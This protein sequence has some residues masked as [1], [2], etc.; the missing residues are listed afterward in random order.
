MSLDGRILRRHEVNVL[1]R[2]GWPKADVMRQLNVKHKFVDLWWNRDDILDRPREGRPIKYTRQLVDRIVHRLIKKGTRSSTRLV[3]QD[4]GYPRT[5]VRRVAHAAGLVSKARHHHP[6]LS[7]KM[8]QERVAFSRAHKNDDFSKILFVDEKKV[9]LCPTPNKHNDRVWVFDDEEPEG[10]PTFAHSAK[11]NVAAGVSAS[12][13]SDIYIF[14]QNMDQ[15]LYKKI[16]KETLI[17]AGKKLGGR[18]WVL[19]QDKDPKHTSKSIQAFL[20]EERIPV[21][22]SP[23]HSPDFNAQDN[24]W[25]M[26]DMELSKLGPRSVPDL[27]RKIKKAWQNIPQEHIQ[28]TVFD[29]P[30]R[31]QKAISLQGGWT[32]H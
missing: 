17:P 11:L 24:V 19:F 6:F 21:L 32:H 18:G 28:K 4:L 3:S 12:G 5:S 7:E 2:A 9:N 14:P 8:K 13:R 1:K 26:F 30:N 20:A 16:L 15:V 23:T 29:I 27:R 10:R 31:L 22:H 25:S